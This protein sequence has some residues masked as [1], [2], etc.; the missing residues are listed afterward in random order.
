MVPKCFV[1]TNLSL[2]FSPIM[3]YTEKNVLF[4]IMPLQRKMN[5]LYSFI[6][7]KQILAG[8]WMISCMAGYNQRSAGGNCKSDLSQIIK[9]SVTRSH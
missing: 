7:L 4:E 2:R 6:A 5:L 1:E 9:G 8:D 3:K